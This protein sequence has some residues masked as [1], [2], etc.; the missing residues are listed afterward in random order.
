MSTGPAWVP[1]CRHGAARSRT[2][3]VAA[4]LALAL[5]AA[6]CSRAGAAG[7]G[8]GQFRMAIERPLTLDPVLASQPTDRFIDSQVFDA[9]VGY[10][11]TT[12]NVV[13]GVAQS[14]TI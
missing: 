13:P 14:W 10:E 7:S 2:T 3:A 1:R 5:L 12:A 8:N 6:A 11:A 4:A 9:L